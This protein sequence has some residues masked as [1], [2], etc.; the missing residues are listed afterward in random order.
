MSSTTGYAKRQLRH[1]RAVSSGFASKRPLHLGQAMTSR[2]FGSRDMP[3][4]IHCPRSADSRIVN[5]CLLLAV[6]AAWLACG[7][8]LSSTA[9]TRVP[10]DSARPIQAVAA[11]RVHVA[12]DVAIVTEGTTDAKLGEKLKTAIE[13][14]LGRRGLRVLPAHER[15]ADLTLRI[16]TRVSGALYFL[17]GHV[18][19]KAERA[20]VAV[21]TAVT[22]REIHRD[23]EFATV[24]A[25]KVVAALLDSPALR[26]FADRRA[27]RREPTRERPAPRPQP[28]VA[29]VSPETAAKAHYGRGTSFYNLGR[30]GEALAEYE[31]AYLAVQDPPFLFNIA[32]C[33]RKMGKTEEALAAYRSYLRVAPNAPN[34]PE[35]QKR[36]AELEKE[37]RA[38]TLTGTRRG[39]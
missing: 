1:S 18:G 25:D 16:E 38:A 8:S 6:A 15:A 22:E 36:I 2:I 33:Q 7:G 32:Q 9:P 12:S 30:Y 23:N 34:R 14:E 19:L 20:G 31:A 21:A 5:R 11:L 4:F 28:A 13:V 27:P 37:T 24:M 39:R 10:A 17:R 26:E 29:K 35:V 3:S